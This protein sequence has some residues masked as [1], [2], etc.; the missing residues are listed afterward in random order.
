VDG[1]ELEVP[2]MRRRHAVGVALLLALAVVVGVVALGRTAALGQSSPQVSDAELQARAASLEQ[3]EADL[4][5]AAAATPPPLPALP[6]APAGAPLAP[7]TVVL[8]DDH[9]DH[10]EHEDDDHEHGFEA[11]DD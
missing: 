5:R 11:D 1:I 2:K 7:T 4:R 10:E 3:A 8:M 9:D 6:S